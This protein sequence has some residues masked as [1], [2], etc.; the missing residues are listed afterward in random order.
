MKCVSVSSLCAQMFPPWA[1]HPTPFPGAP[2]PQ[3]DGKGPALEQ[4]ARRT[5]RGHRA[6]DRRGGEPGGVGE[7]PRERSYVGFGFCHAL[8]PELVPQP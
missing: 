4:R 1:P 2:G 3:T 6:Q 7:Q 5:G 8:Q